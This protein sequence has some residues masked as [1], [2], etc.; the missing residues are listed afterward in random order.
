[1]ERIYLDN[2]ATTQLD[3]EVIDAM[4]PYMREHYGNPSAVHAFGRKARAGIEQSRRMVAK[5]INCAPGEIVFTSCG[6]E[7]D[8]M[9]LMC[10]VR[11]LGVKHIITSPIEHHAV[12]HVALELERTGAAKIHWL[13]PDA[14]RQG[15][16]RASGRTAEDAQQR[17]R[18]ADARQ[19]RT[20]HTQRPRRH[21]QTLPQIQRTFPHGYRADHGP[22]PLRPGVNCPWT[23][24]RAAR[25]SST[26]RK[27]WASSTCVNGSV[28]KPMLVGGSQERNMRAGTENIIGI[29]ALAKAME[30]AYRD[31]DEHVNH[32]QSLKTRMMKAIKTALPEAN[33]NGD[34][35]ADSLYT[36]LNIHFPD[37]GKGEMLIYNM[38]IEGI[39]CSGGSACSSGS[40][41]GSHVIEALYPGRTGS[42]HPVLIQQVQ[43]RGRSG[44]RGGSAAAGDGAGGCLIN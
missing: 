27:A 31:V 32:V 4:L 24:S 40:N 17:P 42:E 35:S 8:N 16:P 21:G 37:D 30:V 18:F 44:P 41:K 1:M 10:S 19:Q 14:R 11:D 13:T 12:E 26:G 43:H 5:L 29:V 22:L 23:S 9:A 25:T 2:A 39:A 34:I 33:F 38:D 20:R 28:L 6:T 15:G 7:A 3:P 36:V